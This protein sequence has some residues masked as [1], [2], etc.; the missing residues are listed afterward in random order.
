V[1]AFIEVPK[2]HELAKDLPV[3]PAK[4]G[5]DEG[6]GL[7]VNLLRRHGVE[8]FESC[9]GGEGHSYPEPTIAFGASARVEDGWHAL[10]IALTYGLPVSELRMTWMIERAGS[11]PT[12]PRWEMVFRHHSENYPG[13]SR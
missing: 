3:L 11:W 13:A 1:T 12:T 8:T 9:Q 7:W 4:Y 10:A 5:L 2:N 6:I